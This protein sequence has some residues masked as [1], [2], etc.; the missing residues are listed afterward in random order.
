MEAILCF[1]IK[2]QNHDVHLYLEELIAKGVRYFV[3]EYIPEHLYE[4]A[5][6]LS[7]KIR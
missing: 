2:G 1:A 6:L 4:K 5:N 3:V 7:L